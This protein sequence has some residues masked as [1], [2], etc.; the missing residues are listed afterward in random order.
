[1]LF[2]WFQHVRL[3]VV[4]VDGEGPL[5]QNHIVESLREVKLQ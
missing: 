2:L 4:F 3:V 1:M 5:G